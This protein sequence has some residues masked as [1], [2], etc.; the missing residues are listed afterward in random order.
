MRERLYE[1]KVYGSLFP[2]GRYHHSK[3]LQTHK[4]AW[5]DM[6]KFMLKLHNSLIYSQNGE[7]QFNNLNRFTAKSNENRYSCLCFGWHILRRQGFTNKF[8]RNV[9]IVSLMVVK[10]QIIKSPQTSF[11]NLLEKTY[12]KYIKVCSLWLDTYFSQI[13]ILLLDFKRLSFEKLQKYSLL[14]FF[15]GSNVLLHSFLFSDSEYIYCHCQ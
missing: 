7:A 1:Q 14:S 4:M 5:H 6:V 3:T 2:R 11:N 15:F 10:T 8:R 9:H 13:L 12:I